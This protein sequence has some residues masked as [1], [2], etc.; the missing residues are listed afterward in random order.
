[1]V[2]PVV[3]VEVSL[4][5]HDVIMREVYKK[6]GNEKLMVQKYVVWMTN[7]E[8]EDSRFP[9]YVMHYTNF[10]AGRADMLKREVRVSSSKGQIM[11]VAKEFIDKNVKKGWMKVS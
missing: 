4:P 7:K 3:V 6:G 10:S 5:E 1:M 11:S 9:A 2:Q 8:K